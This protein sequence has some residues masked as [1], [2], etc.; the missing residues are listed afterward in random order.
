[1]TTRW[2]L[3]LA[4]GRVVTG[5]IHG[6]GGKLGPD[7]RTIERAIRQIN[8]GRDSGCYEPEPGHLSLST[9]YTAHFDVREAI[10]VRGARV[11]ACVLVAHGHESTVEEY[12]ARAAWERAMAEL[13]REEAR[14]GYAAIA[15]AHDRA[16][17]AYDGHAVGKGDS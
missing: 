6:A 8:R 7:R 3:K 11:I 12:R 17:K 10:D 15:A 4:D 5:P 2:T 1:M 9:L 16:A 13:A 14:A